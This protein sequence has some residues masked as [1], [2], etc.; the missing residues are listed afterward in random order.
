MGTPRSASMVSP[1]DQS[2][3]FVEL[4][5]DL[6]FVFSVTQ[7]VGYLHH[8]LDWTG[9][10]H[11]VLIFW[12]V[13]WA[14]TQYTWALNAADTTHP[15]VEL[16]TLLATGI[17]FFMAVALPGAFAGKALWFAIPY[18]VVRVLA[19]ALYARVSWENDPSQHAAVRAF[20]LLSVGGMAAV[21]GGALAG[22]STQFW[23]WGMAILLDCIAAM[24]AGDREGWDLHP[25]HF[26]ERH[27]LF[28][29]IALGES[30]I[31][32]A[33]GLTGA[34]AATRDV[35]GVGVLSVATTCALW[36]TYF[37]CAKPALDRDL[38]HLRGA[39]LSKA[40]RDAYSLFHFPLVLGVIAFAA[41]IEGIV[42]HP[43]DPLDLANRLALGVGVLL[44]TG[45]MALSVWRVTS[46]LPALRILLG[47]ATGGAVVFAAGVS[48]TTTLAI[49]F[50]GS[51]LI[52][53]VEHRKYIGREE[54]A[55]L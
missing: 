52:G 24:S 4:F 40:G 44:F 45:V 35:I 25:D 2:V 55:T 47:A 9:V 12:L 27:G 3:T 6:V 39:E 30:L 51:A 1:E 14:W 11:T 13:W 23:L 46:S 31:V 41:A 42:L 10:G 33:A 50:A 21:L 37:G 17:A 15:A 5:F 53:I 8:H 43:A 20:A 36:W 49:A 19:L 22:G 18:V 34:E 32:A 48:P 54:V 29:I 28:I 7:A 26:A 38:E 16:S